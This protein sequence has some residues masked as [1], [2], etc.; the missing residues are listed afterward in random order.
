MTTAGIARILDSDPTA[1]EGSPGF[2]RGLRVEGP[3]YVFSDESHDR[4]RLMAPMGKT[5]E[6]PSTS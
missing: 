3:V 6:E 5:K 1:L 4:V 2:W